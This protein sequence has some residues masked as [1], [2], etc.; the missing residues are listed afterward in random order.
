MSIIAKFEPHPNN[1]V[2]K[3]PFF[4]VQ[5]LGLG[6]DMMFK[7]SVLDKPLMFDSTAYLVSPCKANFEVEMD[8]CYC[9][10]DSYTVVD[11][12]SVWDSDND[13]VA[14]LEDNPDTSI[15]ETKDLD[16]TVNCNLVTKGH[17]MA[18]FSKDIIPASIEVIST[19]HPISFL[20]DL[21]NVGD[22]KDA[23]YQYRV[24]AYDASRELYELYNV[25][26]IIDVDCAKIK[27]TWHDDSDKNFCYASA[28]G[29]GTAVLVGSLVVDAALGLAS[30]GTATTVAVGI[31]AFAVS[32]YT[33]HSTA[34]PGHAGTFWNS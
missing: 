20:K 9:D 10:K 17:D 3:L 25:D 30:A 14:V 21:K 32:Y 18:I 12:G 22:A 1:M 28:S 31:G 24:D 29:A 26:E 34:W 5:K 4:P 33:T 11:G 2:L 27:D 13:V 19:A 16:G 8:T 6:E 23:F 15:D 7:I